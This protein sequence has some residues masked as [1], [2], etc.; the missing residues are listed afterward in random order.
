MN[1]L[2]IALC[3]YN[4]EEF[5][6][7][8]LNSLQAQTRLPDELVICDDGSTD[9]T[10]SIIQSFQDQANF[11]VHI[12]HNPTQLGSTKNFEHAIL[13]CKG[14]IIF[15]CDQDDIWHPNKLETIATVF[16][17][18]PDIG[19]V[20]SDAQLVDETG[21]PIGRTQWETI[22]FTPPKQQRINLGNAYQALLVRNYITGATLAFR[23]EFVPSFVPI[24]PAWVHDAWIAIIISLQA[25][26]QAIPES[27]IDYRQ[28]SSNQI[29]TTTS[30]REQRA[31]A[32]Q[33]YRRGYE[34]QASAYAELEQ[35]IVQANIA[36]PQQL[37]D[38]RQKIAHLQRRAT[39]PDARW[40]RI[41]SV[42]QEIMRRNYWKYSRGGIKA[43]IRDLIL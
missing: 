5:L 12:H 22:Q 1:Q 29:G 6:E 13:L 33:M 19:L 17:Q 3:T 26:L 34:K 2:S 37:A 38:L 31:S 42:T 23:R 35:H 15:T 32:M 14:D 10:L 40:K 24:S 27:L 20:F 11:P 16:E 9:N 21:N 41:S 28:H 25:G 43:A 18:S 8:H 7:E 4:G 39:M 36:S 30:Q